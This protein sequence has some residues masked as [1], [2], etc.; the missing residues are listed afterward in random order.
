MEFVIDGPPQG[1]KRPRADFRSGRVHED[2]AGAKI[3]RAISKLVRAKFPYDPVTCPVGVTITA[4][5]EMPKSWPKRYHEALAN[6]TLIFADCKPD[7]DNIEKL[8]LDACNAIVW[9]DDAQVVTGNPPVKRYGYPPR[10]E[11][12]IDFLTDAMPTPAQIEREKIEW[13]DVVERKK[14][15]KIA[16]KQAALARKGQTAPQPQAKPDRLRRPVSADLFARSGRID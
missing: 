13:A 3:E 15:A 7:R 12:R 4:I 10:T 16:R 6:G 14:A 1:K 9:R 2:A 8:V 11:V 5:F